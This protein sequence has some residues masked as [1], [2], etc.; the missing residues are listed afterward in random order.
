MVMPTAK[1]PSPQPKDRPQKTGE[2]R[3]GGANRCQILTG[4]QRHGREPVVNATWV[5][6]GFVRANSH[7]RPTQCSNA[8]RGA[9]SRSFFFSF[10]HFPE[11]FFF[12]CVCMVPSLIFCVWHTLDCQTALLVGIKCK[13]KTFCKF[14]YST[15]IEV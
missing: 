8:Q 7:A 2:V 3:G 14:P 10:F 12:T 9:A 5:C 11:V 6:A 1:N 15:S 4:M 13:K